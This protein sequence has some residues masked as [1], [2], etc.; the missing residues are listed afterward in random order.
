MPGLV[1]ALLSAEDVKIRNIYVKPLD[2]FEGPEF[3]AWYYRWAN[4]LH[5]RTRPSFIRRELL[6]KPGEVIDADLLAQSERNLRAYGF[7][8]EAEIEVVPTGDGQSDL[9]VRTEDE[10][11]L[12]LSLSYGK[13]RGA[14]TFDVGFE[15][16]NFLGLGR[17]IGFQFEKNEERESVRGYYSDPRNF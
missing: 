11:T 6:F 9:F 5:M 10:W 14:R 13:S 17:K 15:E 12:E 4:H 3:N 7:L 2:V 1:L 8:S 16:N